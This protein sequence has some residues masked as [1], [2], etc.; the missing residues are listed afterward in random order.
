MTEPEPR[1]LGRHDRIQAPENVL[2][3]MLRRLEAATSRLEDI[4]SSSV[5][6]GETSDAA[7]S[8]NGAQSPG[9]GGKLAGPPTALSTAPSTAPSTPKAPVESLPPVIEAWDEMMNTPLKAWS[10]LSE[11][12]GE[13]VEGQVCVDFRG[14]ERR[15]ACC[16]FLWM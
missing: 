4:A 2:I 15:E 8:V 5:P 9:P 1:L 11:N 16:G 14:L 13:I 12:L 10:E 6:N 3:V 7:P